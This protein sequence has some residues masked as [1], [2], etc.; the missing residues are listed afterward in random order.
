M[1]STGSLVT[2]LI[3]EFSFQPWADPDGGTEGTCPLQTNGWQRWSDRVG[4][5]SLV[6]YISKCSKT[7]VKSHK[8]AYVGL[9][10]KIISGPAG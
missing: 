4:F 10:P 8:I 6:G 3:S 9:M 5:V 2:Y 7:C 1:K